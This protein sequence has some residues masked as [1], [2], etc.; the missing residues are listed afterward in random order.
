MDECL[1]ILVGGVWGL[2]TETAQTCFPLLLAAVV[3]ACLDGELLLTVLLQVL[4]PLNDAGDKH[5]QIEKDKDG[6]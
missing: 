3:V 6:W 4:L 1:Y 2:A 5:R